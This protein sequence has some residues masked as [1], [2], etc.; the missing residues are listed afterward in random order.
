M[1]G[2][3]L[4]LI[5]I[6]MSSILKVI[7][8]ELTY[9]NH[10]SVL[11]HLTK[12]D[13]SQDNIARTLFQ[14]IRHV[15]PINLLSNLGKALVQGRRYGQENNDH[16]LKFESN[17][18]PGGS[19]QNVMLKPQCAADFIAYAQHANVTF[20]HG[21]TSLWALRMVD[22]TGKPSAGVLTGRFLFLG[23]F[24]ECLAVRAN[25]SV[26]SKAL[27]TIVQKFN[28]QYCL[29]KYKTK[30]ELLTILPEV[31]TGWAF[32]VP[33]S[34]SEE[35]SLQLSNVALKELN[36]TAIEFESMACSRGNVPLNTRAVAVFVALG[37]IL[38]LVIL[39][40]L[41]DILM[42]QMPKWRIR[43]E[44]RED[45]GGLISEA[46]FETLRGRR[47]EWQSRIE[48]DPLILN[49]NQPIMAMQT[50]QPFLVRLLVAFSLWSNA[51]K[52]VGTS[53]PPG[54]LSCLNGIRVISI[55]WVVL[56]HTVLHIARNG[57]NV[58]TYSQDAIKRWSFMPIINGTFSVDTF[59]VL[60]AI[61]VSYATLNQMKK[62]GGKFNWIKFYVHRY[63]RLTPVYMI[64][65][66]I[67]LGTLPY[68]IN[69][70]LNDQKKGFEKDPFCKNT[71]WGNPLYIQ[72]LMN[73]K[74]DICMGWS[75]YLAVDMQFYV[76][77]PLF[78]IPL[79]YRP[80][81]GYAVVS[82]F[83]LATTVTPLVLSEVRKYPGS[84]IFVQLK[85]HPQ[86]R[87]D[88]FYDIYISPYSRMG[89]Y[90]VGIM[91]G[92]ILSNLN[93]RSVRIPRHFVLI[94]WLAAIATG[95]A[96]IY[97][98]YPYFKGTDMDPHAASI[99]NALSRTAWALS[100]A[101]IIFS[102]VTGSGG[103]VDTFLSWSLWVPLSRLTYVVYLIHVLVLDVLFATARTPMYASDFT[104]AILY[105]ATL[106]LTYGLAFICSLL[107]E[108]PGLAL[109]KLLLKQ[110]KR[111]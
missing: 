46:S 104:V 81:L 9:P 55:S 43:A 101:W 12:P 58:L 7:S 41:V 72:N 109:E 39:G 73:F 38:A 5:V 85:G 89:P 14:H 92:Y 26:Q 44:V 27:D 3:K 94:G 15:K 67:Y 107:F 103:V 88:I 90:L 54:S 77:S 74:P 17:A 25:Y 98:L 106:S 48:A 47:D 16:S 19:L 8:P 62:T 29:G 87:G 111:S 86:P 99:Y 42:V 65:M 63:V 31:R 80:K 30:T 53:Q 52:L 35:D 56:G 61:L 68:L 91:C 24:D 96:V 93:R 76:L 23:D 108:A 45:L 50:R 6:T 13:L 71:W 66:A 102:C 78:L 20:H 70:P 21:N 69:G 22:A 97:G 59:F 2:I 110:R 84:V 10:I 4:T 51:E 40:T 28:G 18:S 105:L 49:N 100:V 83:L 75:W 36:V 64:V 57:D 11:E 60:S 1:A 82:L 32:C 95:L 34:C 33:D 79:H 37:I